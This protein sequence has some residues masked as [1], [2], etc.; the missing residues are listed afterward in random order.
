MFFL[1]QTNTFWCINQTK[2]RSDDQ[3]IACL[4]LVHCNSHF[5]METVKYAILGV[6]GNR[7]IQSFSFADMLARVINLFWQRV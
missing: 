4:S 6:T 2:L 3:G 7:P 5:V 1:N